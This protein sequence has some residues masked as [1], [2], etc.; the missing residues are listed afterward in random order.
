MCN[1]FLNSA[2]EKVTVPFASGIHRRTQ[3]INIAISV[4]FHEQCQGLRGTIPFAFKI[5]R[6]TQ[7]VGITVGVMFHEQCRGGQFTLPLEYTDGHKPSV[8]LLV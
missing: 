4:M 8:L 6:R 1:F 2:R 3:T 5:H 7:I